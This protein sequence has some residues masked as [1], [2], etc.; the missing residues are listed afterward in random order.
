M[1]EREGGGGAQQEG[2]PGGREPGPESQVGLDRGWGWGQGAR[3]KQK[4]EEEKAVW[5][6]GTDPAPQSPLGPPPSRVFGPFP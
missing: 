1:G 6:A 3:R 2:I 5:G 4:G